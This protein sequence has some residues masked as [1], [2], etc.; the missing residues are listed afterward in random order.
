VST[1][2]SA[3]HVV[4]VGGGV[5]GLSC[6]FSLR[7]AGA[8]VTVLDRGVCGQ[9][10]SLGNGGWI[11]PSLSAPLA[12]PG[13]IRQAL[14]WMLDPKSPLL[15]RPR[16]DRAFLAWLLRFARNTTPARY[17]AG[18]R[19]VLALN[20]PTLR[21]FDA[22]RD[23]GVDFEMHESG[24][25]FVALDDAHV[26]E[27]WELLSQLATLGYPGRLELLDSRAARVLEPALSGAVAGGVYAGEERHVQPQTLTAG[28][29]RWLGE[30]GVEIRDGVSVEGMSA[31]G[32]G[33]RLRTSTG[34]V[35][36]DRVVV[37]AGIWSRGLLEGLGARVPLEAAKGYSVTVPMRGG[38]PRHAL[39]LQEAKVGVS[40]F[41]G[42]LRLSGTLEFAGEDLRLDPRRIAAIVEA[43]GR[44]LEGFSGN[45]GT[46]WAGLRQLLPDALPIIG[47]VPGA[48]GVFVATGHGMLGITLAPATADALTPLVLEDR[49]V[50]AL[51]PLA[52]DRRYA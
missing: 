23:A 13:V 24:L 25:V 38:G 20:E 50:A 1:T 7:Q 36:A 33:W 5:I 21:L 18:A 35:D 2:A 9:A 49:M 15:V 45:E 28:L 44:Y 29:L 47:R 51:E 17:E 34:P 19:A 14:R 48:P 22:F 4:V 41:D 26:A 42:S 10:T 40:P 27:E 8:E 39:M 52:V 32:D 43:A 6:A 37:A 30:A 16:L 3:A 31:T 11:T 12:A 46:P